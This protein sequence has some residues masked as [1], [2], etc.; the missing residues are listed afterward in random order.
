MI[1][2]HTKQIKVGNIIIGGQNKVVIQS[3]CNIKTEKV[4]EVVNQILEME[5]EGLELI[6]VS[7]LDF[8][9][10]A[11]IKEIKKRIHVPIVGDIHYDYRLGTFAV[12]PLDKSKNTQKIITFL[13]SYTL[14]MLF[15]KYFA[16]F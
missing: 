15:L 16:V 6:R 1:R 9:D 7:V 12:P 14:Y 3:M 11:A 5:K 10:A 2:E 13:E 4:D 8:K